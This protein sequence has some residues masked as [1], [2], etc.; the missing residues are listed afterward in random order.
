MANAEVKYNFSL[1]IS[2]TLDSLKKIN[3]LQCLLT[4]KS[5]VQSKLLI[6]S[7]ISALCPEIGMD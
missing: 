1:L 4:I 2:V 6:D 5:N 3:F 7:H